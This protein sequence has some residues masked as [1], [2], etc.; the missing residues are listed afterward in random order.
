MDAQINLDGT[1]LHKPCAKCQDCNCQIT[2]SN[3][4][5]NDTPDELTLLCKTHYFK[6]F[7]EGG[8]YLGGDKYQ[9][10]QGRE[11]NLLANNGMR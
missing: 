2:L 6:R 11:I 4:A 10:K 3:F 7:R 5:K 8:A 1:I 9:K